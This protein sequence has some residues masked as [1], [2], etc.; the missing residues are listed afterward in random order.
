MTLFSH[1][2]LKNLIMQSFYSKPDQLGNAY[3]AYDI[4]KDVPDSLMAAAAT[5]VSFAPSATLAKY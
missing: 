4:H 1:R 2:A 3:P 5:V